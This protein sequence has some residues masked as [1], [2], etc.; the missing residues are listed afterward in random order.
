MEELSAD[1]GRHLREIGASLPSR[2]GQMIPWPDALKKQT[3]TK[4]KALEDDEQKKSER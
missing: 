2:N 3:K 4:L 1:L